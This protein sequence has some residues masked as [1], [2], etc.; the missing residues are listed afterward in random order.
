M[1]KA[2]DRGGRSE[3]LLF[4]LLT[5]DRLCVPPVGDQFG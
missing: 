1:L 5:D 2:S 4:L 3:L